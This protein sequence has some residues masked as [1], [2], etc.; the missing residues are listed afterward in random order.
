[1]S[2]CQ[3]LP[4]SARPKSPNGLSSPSCW[5]RFLMTRCPQDP[6]VREK[7]TRERIRQEVGR[8]IF[9]ALSKGAVPHRSPRACCN[10]KTPSAIAKHRIHDEAAARAD[11]GWRLKC[12]RDRQLRRPLSLGCLSSGLCRT[13]RASRP[14]YKRTFG[15]RVHF[16]RWPRRPA[17]GFFL[18]AQRSTPT[19]ML[20]PFNSAKVSVFAYSFAKASS[21]ATASCTLPYT[22]QL[23]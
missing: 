23:A 22:S 15:D 16:A 21:F 17:T 13:L 6:F 5:G 1:V 4:D 11:R 2:V 9:P 7:F 12:E 14:V 10:R 20:R 8:G 19:A 3:F 18:V